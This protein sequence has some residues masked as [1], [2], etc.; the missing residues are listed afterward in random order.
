MPEEDP[1]H[2][3]EDPVSDQGNRLGNERERCRDHTP[4]PD[5]AVL[6]RRLSEVERKLDQILKSQ[7][8]KR[9]AP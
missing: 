5:V 9:P 4:S 7:Q 3:E 2:R 1:A 6:E 8:E